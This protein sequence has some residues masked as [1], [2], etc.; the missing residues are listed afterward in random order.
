MLN[1]SRVIKAGSKGRYGRTREIRLEMPVEDIKS[2]LLE[3]YR[4]EELSRY[5]KDLKSLVS[6]D[7]FGEV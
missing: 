5:E 1:I 6:L 2:V 3:D 4:L 7:A